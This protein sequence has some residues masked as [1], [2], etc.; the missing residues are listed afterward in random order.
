MAYMVYQRYTTAVKR[1]YRERADAD[2]Q[3]A[4]SIDFRRW[5]ESLEIDP[6]IRAGL[7]EQALALQHGFEEVTGSPSEHH[8]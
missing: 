6:E 4:R 8:R 2:E 1:G 3:L 7:V 5:L